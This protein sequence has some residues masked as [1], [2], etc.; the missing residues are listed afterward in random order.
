MESFID[1]NEKDRD[2]WERY[3]DSAQT[4]IHSPCLDINALTAYMNGLAPGKLRWSVEEHMSFCP[5]CL[6]ALVELRSLLRERVHDA[7]PAVVERA[8]GLVATPIPGKQRFIAELPYWLVNP[9]A[10]LR[11][12]AGC[13]AA[14]VLILA[15]CTA[16]FI[17]GKGTFV[18]DQ[19]NNLS[20]PSGFDPGS[21][22]S[23]DSDIEYLGNQLF[24]IGEL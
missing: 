17:M 6:E 19:T 18:A 23:I 15:A 4:R 20:V 3:R 10:Y 22:G 24:T 2:I 5:A 13:A 14:L 11:N 12:A 1:E 16:G 21:N 8:K 7:P 9:Y